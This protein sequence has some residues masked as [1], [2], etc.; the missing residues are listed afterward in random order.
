MTPTLAFCHFPFEKD[1]AEIETYREARGYHGIEW[2][3]DGWRLMVARERRRR[4]LDRLRSVS[5]V[6]S[7]HAPYTDLEIGHRD[8]EYAKAACR[9]L[10]DYVDA[11]AELGAH[12]VNIHVGTF[13]PSPEELSRENL[14][15]NLTILME[16][17]RRRGVP[18]TIENLR[19]G[20]SS[21]PE[22]LAALLRQTGAP[23]TFDVGHARGC[24]WVLQ[25]KGSVED[26]LF[27]IPTPI[28]ASHI[29]LI[30]R[31]DM[32]FAP[33]AMEDMAPTL[34]ALAKVGC[35]FWVLE[36]HSLQALEQTRRVVDQYLKARTSAFPA[37]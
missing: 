36:L 27:A 34:D 18:L 26:F 35:E 3:L 8:T 1:L 14:A 15:R 4:D 16:H 17:G 11:A 2:S 22:S 13:D 10:Q 21:E 5:P 29:Y 37:S 25:G 20:P 19:G 32:H 33:E 24:A 28:L 9:I 30:E 23:V 7:L 12:H 6:C 31:E